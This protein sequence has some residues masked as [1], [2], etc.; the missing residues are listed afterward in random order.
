MKF[1]T[2]YNHPPKVLEGNSLPSKTMQ[3]FKDEADINVLIARYTNTGMFYTPLSAAAAQ[4]RVPM[5][6][7]Y[8]QL[9]SFQDQQNKLLEVYEDF[10]NLPAKIRDKFG[11]NPALFVEFVGD[12]K[13]ID[14]CVEMGL[15]KRS[16]VVTEVP[17]PVEK[18]G[19]GDGVVV[20]NPVEA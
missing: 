19:T 12:E 1:F 16:K 9:G 14:K 5:F 20:E 6:E 17:D 3:Q 18:V 7:D 11:N 15:F 10:A 4:K 13:N 8:S 2:N